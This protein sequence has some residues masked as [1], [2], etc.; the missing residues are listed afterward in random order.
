M[1]KR[2]SLKSAMRKK[3]SEKTGA[4]NHYRIQLC[5]LR[6]SSLGFLR[7]CSMTVL[8][9]A[10]V[11]IPCADSAE[12]KPFIKTIVILIQE[13]PGHD[14]SVENSL[15]RFRIEVVSENADKQKGLSGRGSLP[16][17]EGMLFVL[18]PDNPSYFWMKGMN[19][20]IDIL[21]FDKDKRFL[22][23]G[24]SLQPCI[25]C[26]LLKPPAHAAYALEINAGLVK[27]LGIRAGD[28]FAFRDE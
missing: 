17:D 19:F 4:M 2:L 7:I 24:E 10:A 8:L 12:K 18:D 1:A 26:T 27:K 21:F 23:A 13:G 16:A 6:V 9:L 20:P 22:S 3:R 11:N 28:I 15:A 25:R 14:M 5:A